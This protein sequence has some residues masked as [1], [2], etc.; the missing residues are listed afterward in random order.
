[1]S[2]KREMGLMRGSDDME[3]SG[4]GGSNSRYGNNEMIEPVVGRSP[5]VSSKSNLLSKLE[6]SP[7]LRELLM[8][9]KEVLEKRRMRGSSSGGGL[10]SE[11]ESRMRGSSSDGGLRS[12]LESRMGGSSSGGGLRS[13]LESRMGGSDSG[14]RTKSSKSSGYRGKSPE[15]AQLY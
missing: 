1:M 6:S 2:R 12:E 9:F 10:R 14:S 7:Q 8:R 5:T 13:E 3:T 4:F 11:L 15:Y